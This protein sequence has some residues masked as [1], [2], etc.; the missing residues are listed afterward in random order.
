MSKMDEMVAVFPSSL[1]VHFSKS[2]CYRYSEGF[3]NTILS[4]VSFK[5]RGDVETDEEWR[6][7]I[8]YVY[9][10]NT[11]GLFLAYRRTPAGGEDR[12]HAQVSVGFGGHINEDD[13]TGDIRQLLQTAGMRE[14]CEEL[15]FGGKFIRPLIPSGFLIGYDT[16]VDRV[17]FGV[18]LALHYTW[19]EVKANDAECE[20][21]G[22]RSQSEL[23]RNP[24]LESWSLRLLLQDVKGV[25]K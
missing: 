17:H 15:N 11:E 2:A 5:R 20:I 25:K 23:L 18:S 22:W 21:I 19:N 13:V 3:L 10:F 7:L 9:L 12:L 14:L 1:L 24:N 6:Q 4:R 8:P 16:A